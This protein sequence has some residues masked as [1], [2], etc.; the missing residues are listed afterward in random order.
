M[1]GR[2]S[3]VVASVLL[4]LGAATGAGAVREHWLACRGSMLSGSVLHGYAY[5]ADFSD[6]C[7]DAMD[8][9]FALVW[10]GGA[11]RWGAESLLGTTTAL[12]LALAWAV[13]V[14]SSRWSPW[15]KALAGLPAL[16]TVTAGVLSLLRG[17]DALDTV[18][19]WLLLAVDVLSVVAF[20]AVGVNESPPRRTMLQAAMV[21]CGTG[22]VGLFPQLAD[23][24][25]MTAFSDANWDTP[26]GSGYPTVVAVALLAV[27]LLVVTL[28]RTPT[29]SASPAPLVGAS[30]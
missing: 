12:L 15:T 26:P 16:A 27:A 5:G 7:L 18:F 24:I 13:V 4:L 21:L 28:V 3:W 19:F 29:R 2:R 22:A 23:Y 1:G 8:R 17:G 6:G 10:P 9:G 11:D 14:L 25:A 20:V 30:I